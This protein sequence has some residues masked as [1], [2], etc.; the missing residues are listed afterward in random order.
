MADFLWKNNREKPLPDRFKQLYGKDNILR[1]T[2]QLTVYGIEKTYFHHNRENGDFITVIG[3]C[4]YPGKTISETLEEILETKTFTPSTAANLKMELAGQYILILKKGGSLYFFNDNWQ[5]R[6]IFYSNDLDMIG[7]SFSVLEEYA[8]TGSKFLNEYKIFEYLAT[9]YIFYYP[10]WLNNGTMHKGISFLRPFEYIEV[11][12]GSGHAEIKSIQF[13]L[14]NKKETQ[15]DSLVNQFIDTLRSIIEN[16]GFRDRPVGLTLTGGYDSRL[17]SSTA[18]PYYEKSELRVGIS[19]EIP[20][21]LEDLAIAEK[22]ARRLKR[23][24]R[25]L[26]TTD[27]SKEIFNFYTEGMSPPQ[28][29]VIAPIIEDS[30][31]YAVGFGGIFGTELFKPIPACSSAD[32]FVTKRIIRTRRFMKAGE[33]LWQQFEAAIIDE[34]HHIEKHYLLSEPNINDHIHILYLLNTGFFGSFMLAPYNIKGLQVEPYGHFKIL[35]LVM[36]LHPS[37]K[38]SSLLIGDGF[39]QKKVLAKINYAVG[40]ITT[41]HKRPMLPVTIRTLPVYLRRYFPEKCRIYFRLLKNRLN[42]SSRGRQPQNFEP[43]YN[44]IY[45]IP[46][47]REIFFKHRIEKK[48]LG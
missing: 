3:A 37:F 30:G 24:L 12:A 34:I 29:F 25:E 26:S 44:N 22:V 11:D 9:Q 4:Y 20:S 43:L 36:K 48:Y 38:P 35:D 21:S 19:R 41:T 5:V 46:N 23:P 32:D 39:F 45:L 1:L 10:A 15:L 16:P 33:N 17:I 28:N 18:T 8:G 2:D 7:S 13:R 6:Q 14:N 40:K 47:G 31:R 27:D 42:I